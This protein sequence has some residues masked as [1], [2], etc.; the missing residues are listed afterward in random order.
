MDYRPY[1]RIWIRRLILLFSLLIRINRF[2]P[3]GSG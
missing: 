2:F 3:D 1:T